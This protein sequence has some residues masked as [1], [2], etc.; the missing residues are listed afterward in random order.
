MCQS[1][2]SI[3]LDLEW[4]IAFFAHKKAVFGP[5]KSVPKLVERIRLRPRCV[6]PP[7][8][9]PGRVEEQ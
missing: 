6:P 9:D 2:G 4:E 7:W 8:D 1:I 3:F 5:E